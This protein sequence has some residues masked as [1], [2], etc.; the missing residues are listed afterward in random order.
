MDVEIVLDTEPREVSVP[1][2]LRTALDADPEASRFFGS[3]SY[4]H[5]SAYVLWV[6]SA[7][8]DETRQR[9]IPEAVRMLKEG[10]KQR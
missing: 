10:R 5:R 4:S 6:D 8:K 3:L 2:D 1:A 7:K 9:R